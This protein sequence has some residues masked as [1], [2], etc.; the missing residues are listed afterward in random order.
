MAADYFVTGNAEVARMLARVEALMAGPGLYAPLEASALPIANLAKTLAP[1]KT[2]NLRR[3]IKVAVETALGAAV[4][5]I[6]TNLIYGPAQEYGATIVPKNAKL[7]H[8]VSDGQDIFAKSVTIPPHPYMRPAFDELW[9]A[10]PGIFA[11]VL[12]AQISGAAA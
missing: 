4:A 11:R 6:G 7:L 8:W 12:G 3:S 10:V 9:P 2:G 5:H 1:W